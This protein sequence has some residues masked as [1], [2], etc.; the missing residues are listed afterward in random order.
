MGDQ[1]QWIKRDFVNTQ[2]H[3][4]YVQNSDDETYVKTELGAS[5]TYP[6]VLGINW[7]TNTDFFVILLDSLVEDTF[8]ETVTKRNILKFSASLF[9]PIELALPFILPSKVLFQK[10]CKDKIHWDNPVPDSVKEQW[11]KYLNN[12]KAIKSVAI[13]RQL[14]CYEVSGKQLHGF[15]DSSG[16]ACSAVVFVRSFCEHDVKCGCGVEKLE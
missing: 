11:I 9:D 8:Y 5:A 16:I 1:L 13:K 4:F 7:N 3:L 15:C 10:S 14:F 12:L 2:S 6:N